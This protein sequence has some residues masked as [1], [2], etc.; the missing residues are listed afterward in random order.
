MMT[1]T[2]SPDAQGHLDRYLKQIQAALAGQSSVDAGEVERDVLGH[3]DAEL[4]GEPEPVS[5]HRLL[6]VLDRLGEPR[7][8][9]AQEQPSWQRPFSALQARPGDWRLAGI[10]F[11]ALVLT[12][13]LF[14]GPIMLWPL[15]PL[16]VVVS[17]VVSRITIALLAEHGESVGTRGWL[18]YPPLIVVYGPMLIVLIAGPA[19][20][21]INLL[22]EEPSQTWLSSTVGLNKWIALPS[23]VILV[24]GCWWALLG[25]VAAQATGM[26]R[27]L[28]RPFATW[29]ERRHAMRLALTGMILAVI[30]IAAL[31]IPRV[32]ATT[33]S[34]QALLP[35]RAVDPAGVCRCR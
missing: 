23:A 12:F 9:V 34:A 22:S 20:P 28:F 35:A 13:L 3:I 24:V 5:A 27:S 18:I 32:V 29:F 21:I 2:L 14:M 19:F 16:L 26:I 25:I 7:E 6:S 33:V 10:S 30:A 15:P 8:W 17:F 1:V 11:G 4:V 31:T